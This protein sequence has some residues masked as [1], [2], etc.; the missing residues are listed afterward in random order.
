M[1]VN[2][3]VLGVT[4]FDWVRGTLTLHSSITIRD[5]AEILQTYFSVILSLVNQ[6]EKA[7][8]VIKSS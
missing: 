3:G 5:R 4:F 7:S 8:H 1:R 2:L 6:F